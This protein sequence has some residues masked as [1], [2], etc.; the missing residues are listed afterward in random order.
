MLNDKQKKEIKQYIKNH[1]KIETTRIS[2]S[3]SRSNCRADVYYASYKSQFKKDSATILIKIPKTD[4]SL[5]SNIELH[6]NYY[7]SNLEN[8]M[9][10]I[11][12]NTLYLDLVHALKIIDNDH[13]NFELRISSVV[14][15]MPNFNP[16]LAYSIIY[17]DVK[18]Q[19]IRDLSI[20][21]TESTNKFLFRAV[22]ENAIIYAQKNYTIRN[23]FNDKTEA[24]KFVLLKIIDYLH[25]ADKCSFP[26]D[27]TLSDFE[28][29]SSF[30][31]MVILYEK[32]FC[33]YSMVV[34]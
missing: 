27:G 25:Y 14:D 18:T 34:V 29:C 24:S 4:D 6:T 30:S 26:F 23:E 16:E 21:I 20:D 8:D 1:F 10:H 5:N 13:M 9:T 2:F 15:L 31:D 32:Y 19:K 22:N 33:V 7:L 11:F 3:K 28:S 17:K 12:H